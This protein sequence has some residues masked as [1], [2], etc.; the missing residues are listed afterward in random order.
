MTKSKKTNKFDLKNV[1][2]DDFNLM[3]VISRTKSLINNNIIL[4]SCKDNLKRLVKVIHDDYKLNNSPEIKS[5]HA[6]NECFNKDYKIFNKK[7]S[8]KEEELILKDLFLLYKKKGYK[9][10]NF[11]KTKNNLFKMDPLLEGNTHLMSNIFLGNNIETDKLFQYL[12]KLGIIVSERMQKDDGFQ[13]NF[14]K[15]MNLK[16]LPSSAE[17][18]EAIEDLKKGILVLKRLISIDEIYKYTKRGRR[19]SDNENK[20]KN[21]LAAKNERNSRSRAPSN[22]SQHRIQKLINSIR[23]SNS[24]SNSND[25]NKTI[26]KKNKNFTNKDK[27]TK[28]IYNNLQFPVNTGWMTS[29]KTPKPTNIPLINLNNIKY[30]FNNGNQYTDSNNR[31]LS[32]NFNNNSNRITDRKKTYSISYHN[33]YNNNNIDIIQKYPSQK[34]NNLFSRNEFN[35]PR[36]KTRIKKIFFDTSSKK[37]NPFKFPKLSSII[38]KTENNQTNYSDRTK[39]DKKVATFSY[40]YTSRNEFINFAYNKFRKELQNENVEKYIKNYLNKVKGYDNEKTE[41]VLNNLYEQNIR[42]VIMDMDKGIKSNNIY[43]KTQR[44][45]LHNHILKRVKPLLDNMNKN[46]LIICGLEKKLTYMINSK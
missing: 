20:F 42:N 46:D 9:F 14:M 25:S 22:Y 12:K 34:N 37:D 23:N 11:S 32:H 16:K 6:D 41:K 15:T 24:N 5:L 27:S 30:T 43:S 40:P 36:N 39:S 45:Y 4:N 38:S 18:K 3:N 31:K 7:E 2:K 13:Q 19:R 21:K 1:Y 44:L 29:S 17:G 28:T 8:S 26:G 35:T 33:N 10:S